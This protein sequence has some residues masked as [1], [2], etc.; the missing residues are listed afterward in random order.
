MWPA[1][2][3]NR[4]EFANCTWPSTSTVEG[5][6]DRILLLDIHV[7]Q[8][9]HEAHGRAAD[10]AADA[11][12]IGDRVVKHGLIPVQCFDDDDHAKLACDRGG[13]DR[14][15]RSGVSPPPQ[16]AKCARSV[17]GHRPPGCT[18]SKPAFR[19]LAMTSVGERPGATISPSHQDSRMPCFIR[20]GPTPRSAEGLRR[21]SCPG[22]GR[23]R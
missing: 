3:S 17:P 13:A 22:G 7:E 1:P 19:R 4:F 14:A 12:H 11:R 21:R 20:R 5:R 8:V 16:S 23:L 10:G 18:P 2:G 6:F 9:G 15:R